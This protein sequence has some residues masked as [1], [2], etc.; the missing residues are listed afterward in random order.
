MT[1]LH[2][3]ILDEIYFSL[4]IRYGDGVKVAR[5][6]FIAP[7]TLCYGL[8]KLMAE[9]LVTQPRRGYYLENLDETKNQ[10]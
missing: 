2:D 10:T 9:G 1:I 3:T 7:R 8:K 5:A 4:P 6:L